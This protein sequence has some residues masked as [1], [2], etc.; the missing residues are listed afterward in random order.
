MRVGG[1][2][3]V[4]VQ[5][6]N[7]FFDFFYKSLHVIFRQSI[8]LYRELTHDGK[9]ALRQSRSSLKATVRLENW[10]AFVHSRAL[11]LSGRFEEWFIIPTL[12]PCDI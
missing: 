6:L 4:V 12:V 2:R 7:I 11:S 9:D 10:H 8:E 5:G 3:G 1:E